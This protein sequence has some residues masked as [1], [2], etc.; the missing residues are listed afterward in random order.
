[1]YYGVFPM[2]YSCHD[3]NVIVKYL[4]KLKCPADETATERN[5]LVYLM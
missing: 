4:S 3:L 1:M 5:L 2:I